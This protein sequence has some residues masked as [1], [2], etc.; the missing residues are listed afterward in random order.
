MY[1]QE[2]EVLTD[3]QVNFEL[4]EIIANTLIKGIVIN[5]TDYCPS[6]HSNILNPL[7]IEIE[8][9]YKQYMLQYRMQGLTL[10]DN[11]DSFYLV[12]E[13]Y[14]GKNKQAII[15]KNKIYAS[16]IVL[17]RCITHDEGKLYDFLINI[18]YG[19]NEEH[20]KE[21]EKNEKIQHILEKSR[22]NT[23]SNVLKFLYEKNFLLKTKNNKFILTD[24]S[25]RIVDEII[26][27]NKTEIE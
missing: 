12:D 11:I 13:K 23:I 20:L 22:V 4:S 2:L 5:K 9:N 21:V 17:V 15:N 1:Q 19:V 24:A 18:N 26:S 27:K 8:R 25:K 7:F 14:D 10:V 6:T 3:N 16:I